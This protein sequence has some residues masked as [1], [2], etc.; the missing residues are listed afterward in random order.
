MMELMER[1]QK[2]VEVKDQNQVKKEIRML[3]L[4]ND[5]LYLLLL[6][7][8]NRLQFIFLNYLI[9][10]IIFSVDGTFIRM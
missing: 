8:R 2:R 9:F 5:N 10:F 6:M 4:I 1:V 3:L 7:I